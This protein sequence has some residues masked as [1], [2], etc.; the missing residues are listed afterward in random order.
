MR[1]V[2]SVRAALFLAMMVGAGS[3]CSSDS[4]GTPRSVD[5]GTGCGAFAPC[6]GSL[7]GTWSLTSQCLNV[8]EL[9][10]SAQ[11]GFFCP[12]AQVAAASASVSGTV[13]F[14]GDNSF[15]LA[16]DRTS[17]MTIDFPIACTGG[18]PCDYFGAYIALFEPSGTSFTCSGTET[19][20]CSQNSAGTV[21]DSGTYVRSGTDVTLNSAT[22]SSPMTS[23]YCV[24]D[25]TLH[26]LSVD[27]TMST[28]PGGQATIRSD[29]IARR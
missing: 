17:S 15:T 19:C 26:L 25:T 16:E 27:P 7:V 28:G 11:Q 14:G 4:V 5:A 22:G 2:R 21:T 8:D 6:G 13:T 18:Y 9:T 3:S 10:L 12:Q 1:R 24:V 23:A 20:V 29:I